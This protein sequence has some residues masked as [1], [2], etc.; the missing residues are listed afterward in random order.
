MHQF[1]PLI[2][3]TVIDVAQYICWIEEYAK[4]ANYRVGYESR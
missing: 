3:S 1:N 4:A 2:L